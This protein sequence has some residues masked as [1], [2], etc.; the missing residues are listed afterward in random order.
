MEGHD[1]ELEACE[2]T[3]LRLT[4]GVGSLEGGEAPR[5]LIELDLLRAA[6]AFSCGPRRLPPYGPGDIER[7]GCVYG[8]LLLA[9]GRWLVGVRGRCA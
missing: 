6:A 8:A 5:L 1:E 9:R 4:A 3:G 7:F 2:G